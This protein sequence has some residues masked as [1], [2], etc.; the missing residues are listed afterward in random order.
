MSLLCLGL[1]HVPS[2]LACHVYFMLCSIFFIYVFASC[3]RFIFSFILHPSCI[4]F[5]PCHIFFSFPPSSWF[6]CLF[7]TKRGNVYFC[8]FYMTLMHI[9]RGINSTSCT[10]V[11]GEIHWGDAYIKGEKTFFYEIT[12]LYLML[13]FSVFYGA[14]SSMLYCSHSIVFMC[15]TC[16]H[17]YVC[18]DDHLLCYVVIVV[19]S[20][21][22]FWCMIKL[23]IYFTSCLL[24]R[25][26]LVALFLSFYYLLYLEGL[27]CFVQVFQVT[28][29]YVPSSS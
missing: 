24:D 10:F 13:V 14:L 22:L 28:S 1:Y 2:S 17:S 20:I 16:I 7:V 5:Y 9:L 3:L 21:W 23:L 26:L 18:S 6:I 19:I 8:H 29:I 11:G 4:I 25:N 15:W 27:I 12:L